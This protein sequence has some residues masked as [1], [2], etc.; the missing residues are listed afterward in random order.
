MSLVKKNNELRPFYSSLFDE[1]FNTGMLPYSSSG[2][3]NGMPALNVREDGKKLI[4]DVRIPG[5]KKEDIKLEYKDGF[6]TISGESK[7]EREEGEEKG[8]YLRR[9]FSTYSFRRTIELP[10]EKY[11][12]AEAEASYNDGILEVIM[13]RN[14]ETEKLHKTIEVR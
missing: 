1:F 3:R 9:E 2:E 6:L 7:E 4:L 13:P 11:N 14:E 10:E 5:M 12:V 8:K